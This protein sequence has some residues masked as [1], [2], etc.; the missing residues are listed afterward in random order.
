MMSERRL[1][2]FRRGLAMHVGY[3][4]ERRLSR[5]PSIKQPGNFLVDGQGVHSSEFRKNVMRMLMIHQRLT[6]I[7]F[8]SLKKLRKAGMRR[9]QRLG[10]KHLPQQK[11]ARTQTM[12][13][14]RHHVICRFRLALAAWPTLL[15]VGNENRAMQH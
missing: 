12:L 1:W 9:G 15:V 4:A 8:A 14:H 7:S 11:H 3:R 6:M 2:I 13:L 5:R 10:G